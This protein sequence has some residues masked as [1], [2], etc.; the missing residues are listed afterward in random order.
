[1]KQFILFSLIILL[2]SFCK[3]KNEIPNFAALIIG[4]WGCNSYKKDD[5]DTIV[6]RQPYSLTGRYE[7]GWEFF[8][9]KQI[10]YKHF[11]WDEQADENDSFI[12]TEN[13]IL[14][15]SAGLSASK[16]KFE[17]LELSN[18]KL[19]VHNDN[20]KATWFLTKE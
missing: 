4:K 18:N 1:M 17:I 11:M 6:N 16:S 12:L 2:F 13:K 19:T 10:R 9:N 7:H 5:A 14:T 15:I 8:P 3:K 20:W